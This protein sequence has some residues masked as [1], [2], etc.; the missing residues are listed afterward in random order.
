VVNIGSSLQCS[1]TGNYSAYAAAKVTL[2]QTMRAFVRENGERGTTANVIA[3]GPLDTPFFW[4]QETQQSGQFATGLSV[5]KRLG[6]VEDIAS[7]VAFLATPETQW[8]NG[9]MVFVNGGYLA[10]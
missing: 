8:V 10:R 1:F 9:Q 3:P 2:D 4:G 5:Q 6:T 7:V